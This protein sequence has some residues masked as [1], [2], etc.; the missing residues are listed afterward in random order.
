MS[1]W[2]EADSEDVEI[3][4]AVEEVNIW[5]KQDDNGNIYVTLTF[6]QI[7]KIH[8][9]ITKDFITKAAKR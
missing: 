8:E 3:N 9:E 4:P 7:R 5:V 2:I 6:D 1:E